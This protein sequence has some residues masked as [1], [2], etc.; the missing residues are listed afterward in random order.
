[1]STITQTD[2]YNARLGEP[3]SK[4]KLKFVFITFGVLVMVAIICLIVALM[5]VEKSQEDFVAV[6]DNTPALQAYAILED[7]MSFDEIEEAVKKIDSNLE[8]MPNYQEDSGVIRLPGA[9]DCVAFTFY[10]E[11]GNESVESEE[12]ASS[13]I[14]YAAY[15]LAYTIEGETEKTLSYDAFD[16]LYEYFDGVDVFQFETKQEA[17]DALLT[18]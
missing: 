5:L 1:M 2:Y 4:S 6:R 15:D 12:G 8:V 7:G 17:I 3:Q 14:P 11:V 9:D 13:H 16:Q 18:P 10:R